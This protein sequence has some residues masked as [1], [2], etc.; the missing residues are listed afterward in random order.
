MHDLQN[1][2]ALCKSAVSLFFV[3]V[4]YD[5]IAL[6]H[7]LFTSLCLPL[8]YIPAQYVHAPTTYMNMC[9]Q[10]LTAFRASAC[11]Y[12]LIDQTWSMRD[13]P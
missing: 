2:C 9:I 1:I 11:Q 10:V 5:M 3:Y 4:K 12:I 7:L 8:N 6:Q 13:L